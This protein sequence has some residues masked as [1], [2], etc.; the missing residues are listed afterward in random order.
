M[1]ITLVAPRDAAIFKRF[2]L[3][4]D[5]ECRPVFHSIGIEVTVQS[6]ASAR[7]LEAEGWARKSHMRRIQ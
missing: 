4:S 6:E 7:E 3:D 5:E 2:R 1:G